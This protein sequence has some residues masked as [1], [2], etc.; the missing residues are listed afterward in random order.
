MPSVQINVEMKDLLKAMDFTMKSAMPRI[1]A[2][3]MT[4]TAFKAQDAVRANLSKKYTLRSKNFM[5]RSINIKKAKAADFFKNSLHSEV[6]SGQK[7]MVLHELGKD[8]TIPGKRLAIPMNDLLKR[9]PRS[10]TGK[11]RN[12]WLPKALLKNKR[13]AGKTKTG[14]ERTQRF[15]H[16]VVGGSNT[17]FLVRE[18]TKSERIEYLYTFVKKA[19]IK[20]TFGF[21]RTVVFHA[22]ANYVRQFEKAYKKILARFT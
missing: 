3:A 10:A 17:A 7:F 19:T 8:K 16:Y 4:K 11:I 9:N 21:E 14:R 6:R 22:A 20:K 12:R 2:E 13:K 1:V 18:D 5:E 15:R